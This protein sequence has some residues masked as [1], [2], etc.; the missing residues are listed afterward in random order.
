MELHRNMPRD[1]W[2][3]QL[4][5]QNEDGD[6]KIKAT[7]AAL[8]ANPS[9]AGASDGAPV[10]PS[11]ARDELKAFVERV[12]RM[13]EE[14]KAI[15]DDIADIYREAKGRGVNVKALRTVVRV[16]AQDVNERKEQEAIVETYMHA[17]GML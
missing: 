12:E 2:R 7:A 5:A 9:R 10:G 6:R 15:G 4:R 16:R 1:E 11:F 14:K 13:Q 8:E 17:L 3:T